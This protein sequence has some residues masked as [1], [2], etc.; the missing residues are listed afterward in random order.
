MAD[1]D[2]SLRRSSKRAGAWPG[3]AA[4]A[5][6][7]AP[8]APGSLLDAPADLAVVPAVGPATLFYDVTLY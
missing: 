1:R 5:M 8:A 6:N 2:P 4:L 7:V 3:G